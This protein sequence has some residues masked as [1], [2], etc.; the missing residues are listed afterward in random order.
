MSILAA[1]AGILGDPVKKADFELA[2]DF[3]IT[4]A[5]NCAPHKKSHR[6]SS[7]KSGKTGKSNNYRG[8]HRGRKSNSR[9]QPYPHS[10]P[11]NASGQPFTPTPNRGSTGV[12]LWYYSDADYRFLNH[13]MKNEL[14]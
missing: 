13:Q 1:K 7:L 10:S 11:Q 14:R 9:Y 4:V 5:P 8:K 2:A 3:L 6:I 12:E